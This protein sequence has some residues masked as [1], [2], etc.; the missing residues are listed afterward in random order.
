MLQGKGLYI[1]KLKN[2]EGGD[3]KQAAKMAKAAGITHVLIK[4][5]SGDWRYNQRSVT[6][7]GR[8]FWVDDILG[9]AVDAFHAEGIDVW[10]WGWI[11]LVNPIGEAREAIKRVRDFGLKGYVIDA[12][13]DAKNKPAQTATY[14]K[15]LEGIGVPVGLSSYRFPLPP[16]H[17]EIAWATFLRG[18][19]YN[20]PQV[21]WIHSHNP[22]WQLEKSVNDFKALYKKHNLPDVPIIPTGAA[23]SEHG[24]A[25]TAGEVKEFMAKA[26]AMG[27]SG[28]NFWEWNEA[29][30]L[31]LFEVIGA[32][33][34]AGKPGPGPEPE[35]KPT[36]TI[37]VDEWAVKHAYPWMVGQGYDGPAPGAGS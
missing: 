23:F 8:Q 33:P 17:P 26:E 35:P 32:Y 9:P 36:P 28:C 37:P 25:A 19:D 34:W 2:A 1:W 20:M 18:C 27:L 14:M 31:G 29:R 3:V 21:Y 12:E 30:G 6:Q 24:W 5:L 11:Y 13:G 7:N 16:Y 4:V 22:A 10:G 15:H